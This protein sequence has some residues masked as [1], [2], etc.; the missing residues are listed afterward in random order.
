MG[1]PISGGGM[2][3]VV[4]DDTNTTARTVNVEAETGYV[5]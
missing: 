4:S 2:A 1:R 3:I 5:H